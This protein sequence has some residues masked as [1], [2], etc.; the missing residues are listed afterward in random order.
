MNM[1]DVFGVCFTFH[2]KGYTLSF[3]SKVSKR[4][5]KYNLKEKKKFKPEQNINHNIF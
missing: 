4:Q 2:F 3:N 1:T 5:R